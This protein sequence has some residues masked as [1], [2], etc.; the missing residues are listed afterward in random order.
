M[1]RVCACSAALGEAHRERPSF[2]RRGSSEKAELASGKEGLRLAVRPLGW[3]LAPLSLS[4][5]PFVALCL[6]P[7]ARRPRR[8]QSGR[9][10]RRA[11]LL[12][13]VSS[14]LSVARADDNALDTAHPYYIVTSPRSRVPNEYISWSMP[15]APCFG[16]RYSSG[17]NSKCLPLSPLQDTTPPPPSA[18]WWI[19]PEPDNPG[20]YHIVSG[21]ESSRPGNV[22]DFAW[23]GYLTPHP[24]WLG[25]SPFL[26]Y[27]PVMTG[28][29]LRVV[30]ASDTMSDADSDLYFIITHPTC[31]KAN[32]MLFARFVSGTKTAIDT[33]TPRLTDERATWRLVAVDC[34]EVNCTLPDFEAIFEEFRRDANEQVIISYSIILGVMLSCSIWG[35]YRL[36]IKRAE[37]REAARL[38]AGNSMEITGPIGVPTRDE[39][40]AASRGDVPPVARG[41]QVAATSPA[42]AAAPVVVQVAMVGVTTQ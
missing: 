8:A 35:G 1:A 15:R 16:T 25:D 9:R 31:G 20:W 38:R 29:R 26:A 5:L 24:Y 22:I 17:S 41:A 18:L 21:A 37:K 3:S 4:L 6:L 13:L 32:E 39:V 14:T 28:A 40:E 2:C 23:N 10:M 27:E 11:I 12:P 42:D 33:W 7:R 36:Y 30:S 19:I 34:A